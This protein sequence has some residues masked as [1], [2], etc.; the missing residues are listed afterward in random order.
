MPRL[1][2][3]ARR[4][5]AI[6]AACLVAVA[7]PGLDKV[8][9]T[10]R[11]RYDG[12]VVERVQQ[13]RAALSQMQ[14]KPEAEQLREANDFFNR[15]VQFLDDS[16]VWQQKDY[17]ATPLETLAKRAGD[18]EDFVIAK[19]LSLRQLGVAEEKLRLIYVRAKIGG[20][21]SSLTQAH[22]VLGYFETPT[23]EPLV[24]DNLVG[25]IQPA[26]RRTDLFPVF[27][28]NSSG[29]WVAGATTAAAR[30]GERLSRWRD[31]I[32]RLRDE[33]FEQ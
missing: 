20:E 33:G 26:S 30:P 27:S 25:D 22:M 16:V 15:Q 11:L 3:A 6:A 29:L 13:W 2:Q 12:A 31:L 7:E 23:S 21:R 24:L 18:C 8:E 1:G 9:Q 32:A 10:A 14:D 28:F 5:L 4:T 19:Y 17:W